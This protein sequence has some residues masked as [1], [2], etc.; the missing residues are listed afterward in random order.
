MFVWDCIRKN[1]RHLTTCRYNFL[2]GSCCSVGTS[3]DIIPQDE[4]KVGF[5]NNRPT[6][7]PFINLLPYELGSKTTTTKATSRFPTVPSTPPVHVTELSVTLSVLNNK[8]N[9]NV[10]LQNGG[11]SPNKQF[12]PQQTSSYN[13][14]SAQTGPNLFDIRTKVPYIP[15]KVTTPVTTRRTTTTSTTTSTTTTTRRPSTTKRTTTTRKPST[16]KRTTI[17]PTQETTVSKSQYTFK[18]P[19][20]I[21]TT[22]PPFFVTKKHTPYFKPSVYTKRITSTTSTTTPKPKE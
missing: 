14:Y 17:V 11:Q 9:N 16:T 7:K 12:V 13:Y 21:K 19:Y 3:N 10:V 22:P 15:F 8:D 6:A 2:F 1:G 4:K 5:Y 18:T 20:R